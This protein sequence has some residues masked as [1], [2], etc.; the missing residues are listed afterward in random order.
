MRDRIRKL[1][2][3]SGPPYELFDSSVFL[4]VL[5]AV[6]YVLT[7]P[8]NITD[9]ALYAPFRALSSITDEPAQAW[10]VVLALVASFGI[11]CSYAGPKWVRRGNTVVVGACVF[12]SGSFVMGLILFGASPRAVISAVL[13]GW[14]ASGLVRSRR[15][16]PF[17]EVPW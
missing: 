12:A 5:G 15:L 2:P 16:Y 1:R 14:I 4:F 7:D 17:R 8:T 11:A 13:Y 10:G 3:P 9:Q 6:G